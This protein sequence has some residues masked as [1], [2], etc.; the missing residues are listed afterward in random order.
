MAHFRA[1]I[2]PEQERLRGLR[3]AKRFWTRVDVRE[4][5]ACWPWTSGLDKDGYGVI[6]A[7]RSH[8]VAW[9]ISYGKEIP[10]GLVILHSCDNP[11][12]CNP[13]HLRPGTQIENTRDAI[14]KG[15]RAGVSSEQISQILELQGTIPQLQ[16][17]KRVG[18]APAT[19]S[20][21]L[22]GRK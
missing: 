6:S 18:L 4:I 14:R 17:A 21:V 5:D 11:A 7:K 22:H 8:R 13:A 19:V 12:C 16:I 1:L 15:R 2:R 20:R 10:E 9:E 3:A